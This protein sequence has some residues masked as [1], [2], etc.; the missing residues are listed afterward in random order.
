MD[1]AAFPGAD[2]ADW[3][4]PFL[5][6]AMAQGQRVALATLVGV[7]GS[8]PRPIGSQLAVREDGA[9]V[10]LISGGC[11]EPALVID[12]VAAMREGRSSI[13][14]YG[15]GSRFIDIRL[16]CGS[17]IDVWFDTG[18][19]R[20]IVSG[21]IKARTERRPVTLAIDTVRGDR[22]LTAGDEKADG[23]FLRPYLPPCR[24]VIAGAGHVMVALAQLCRLSEFEVELISTDRLTCRMLE[25]HGFGPREVHA[26]GRFDWRQ[27]DRWSGAVL[28][29][30]DHDDEAEI[31]ASVLDTQAFYIGALGSRRTHERRCELLR[32]IG[33]SE[34]ALARVNGPIGLDIG[35]M[36]PPEIAA[37]I[38]AEIIA[39]WRARPSRLAIGAM[40]PDVTSHARRHRPLRLMHSAGR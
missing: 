26:W 7:T 40:S 5:D 23:L 33:V 29:S 36:T 2:Y 8:S 16:P 3:V 27:L 4:L 14:R 6:E 30:H 18:L 21:L 34:R 1:L 28:L 20:D 25:H 32:H 12:A 11:V 15:Q 38:L 9:S 13:E 37:S 22:W 10:G 19:G 17:G 35:A 31:L 39:N 24:I